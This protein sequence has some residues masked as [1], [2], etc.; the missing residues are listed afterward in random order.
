M[1][2]KCLIID[3]HV[4]IYPDA[5]LAL[6]IAR[7]LANMDEAKPDKE[8]AKIWLLTERADCEAFVQLQSSVRI[9]MYHILPTAEPEALRIQLGER[10]VLYI[11]AGRQV[12]TSEGHELGL[13]ATGLTLP[14]REL[15]AAG[16]IAA[17]RE[18][19]ALAS[20]NW[21][22]G[23]WSGKRKQSLL[24]L[25]AAPPP[26]HLLIGDSAMRPTFW[27]EPGLM[28]A[29]QR[30]GWRVLA[31]SDPLP[32]AGEEI[33]F[34]RYGIILD[35]DLDPDQPVRSLKSLLMKPETTWHIWGNRRGTWE[36]ARRQYAL[37][38]SKNR[39]RG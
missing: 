33:S 2:E 22:P 17:A 25:F 7:G 3:A 26:P 5:D 18:A 19:G 1:S 28:R 36:F 37:M 21:A 14:D 11:M 23:K 6:A 8:T 30:Q 15:D 29:A 16:C 4:H 31:G 13:L 27:P 9:G 39:R 38:R 10:I 34:G 35:G 24:P 32:F 12:V 20:I